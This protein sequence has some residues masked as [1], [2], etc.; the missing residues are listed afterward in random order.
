MTITE[1]IKLAERRIV[2]LEAAKNAAQSVGDV[3]AV[4]RADTALAEAQDT[5]TKLRSVL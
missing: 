1:L 2:Y 5:L 4:I 3:V